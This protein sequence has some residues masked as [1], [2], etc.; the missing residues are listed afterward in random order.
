MLSTATSRLRRRFMRQQ[1]P[2]DD[3]ADGIDARYPRIQVGIHLHRAP[4]QRDALRLISRSPA[5]K[6]QRPVATSTTSALTCCVPL[7]SCPRIR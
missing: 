5:V 7:S 2:A 1:H 3:I 6:G 4:L